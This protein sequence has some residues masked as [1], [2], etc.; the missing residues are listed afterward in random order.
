MIHFRFKTITTI[1]LAL[2]LSLVAGSAGAQDK[3]SVGSIHGHTQ[4]PLQQ[5]I[6]DGLVK[7]TQDH[8]VIDKGTKFLYTFKT[9]SNG[10]YTGTGIT[11]GD[12][13]AVLYEGDKSI[14]FQEKVTF[15]A[16]QDTKVDFDMSRQAYIDKMS[17][18]DK[19]ALED[20]KKKNAD[21][22]A[23][24]G[25]VK[26]L[27]TLLTQARAARTATP[28][29]ND[30]AIS[31]MTQA[32]QARPTEPV[33]WYELGASYEAAKKYDQATA[34][35]QKAVDLDA[36]AKTSK[37]ES[38]AAA[39]SLLAESLAYQ[40]KVPDADAACGKAVAA[41]APSAANCY[42]NEAIALYKTGASNPTGQAADYTGAAAAADKATA[43]N[44]NLA[45]AYYVKGQSLVGNSTVDA[46]G[47]LVAP[48]GCMEAYQKYLQIAPD[49]QYAAEVKG[50]L[51][52]F[53]QTLTNTY[54]AGKK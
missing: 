29:D 9:D 21:I 1:S 44:P 26:N 4:N 7:L 10:D 37:P 13:S 54:K 17:P 43:A 5:P 2:G 36:A 25:V 39:Y 51:T 38:V 3:G 23:S 14:D 41:S 34:A 49:G 11:A 42:S 33:L 47:K 28:P 8:G 12:Y 31:L 40:S 32:T 45:I 46:S 52:G 22:M 53:G 50:I 18:A 35:L 16:G 15:V 27:N 6:T 48:P 19:K 24:N 20:T 30:K